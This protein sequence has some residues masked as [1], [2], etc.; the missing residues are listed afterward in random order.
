MSFEFL[1]DVGG[2]LTH[3]EHHLHILFQRTSH[4]FWRLFRYFGGHLAFEDV[5]HMKRLY[6]LVGED[7]ARLDVI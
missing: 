5:A 6:T 7:V 1:E 4:L 2:L 3:F